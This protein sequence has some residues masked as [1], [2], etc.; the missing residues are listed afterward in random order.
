MDIFEAI[1]TRRSIRQFQDKPVPNLLVKKI[2]AAAMMAPSARNGQPWQFL[3]I[4][5]RDLLATIP[6]FH[7]HAEMVANAPLAI[8]VC[9]DLSLE[10]SPGYWVIDCALAIQNLLLAAHAVGLGAVCTGVHPREER[11]DGFRR[12]LDLPDH[13]MPHSLIPLGYPGETPISE[14]RYQEDR[15]HQN[16]WAFSPH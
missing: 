9:G 6:R 16:R 4:N 1:H 2:L 14:D 3:V 8:L 10:G 11:V 15:V 5:D 7:P 13:I 12:L